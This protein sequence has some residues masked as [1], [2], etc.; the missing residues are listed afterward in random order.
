MNEDLAEHIEESSDPSSE[1]YLSVSASWELGFSDY[2][3][4]KIKGEGKN[5]EAGELI[6]KIKNNLKSFGGTG[7]I[8]DDSIYRLVTGFV[9]P[10]GIGL[11]E[12]PAADVK[13]VITKKTEEDHLIIEMML[14]WKGIPLPSGSSH[15]WIIMNCRVTV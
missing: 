14:S 11:T 6:E 3:I 13:G 4:V 7:K 9:V 15:S 12:T 8:E 5:V 1:N 2:N 10:L